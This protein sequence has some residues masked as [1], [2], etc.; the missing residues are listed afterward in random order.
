MKTKLTT[1]LLASAIVA[2]SCN[3]PQKTSSYT[4]AYEGIE[5]KFDEGRKWKVSEQMIPHLKNSFNLI[6]QS[7]KSENR[8]YK[9]LANDLILLKDKFVT[10]CN[11]EGKAHDALHEWLMPYMELLDDLSNS[12]SNQ[13]SEEIF[14]DILTSKRLFNT[15]FN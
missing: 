7:E 14:E 12:K 13:K 3:E 6:E 1:V 5:L 10:S 8:D 9:K 4:S 15:Y 2:A 11:M